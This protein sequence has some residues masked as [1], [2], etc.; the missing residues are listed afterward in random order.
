MVVGDL[1]GRRGAWLTDDRSRGIA[2]SARV[3]LARNLAGE[4]FP[5]WADEAGRRRVLRM[6]VEAAR[7]SGALPESIFISM[8]ETGD[9]DA[10]I[11]MERRLISAE[12]ADRGPGGGLLLQPD[13]SVA[14]LVNEEDHLR[15]QVIQPGMD[16]RGA[17]E[18][19]DAV[20][21]ALEAILAYAFSSE[22]GYL[23]ACPSNCGT[24]LRAS[25]MLHLLGLRLTNDLE[26][27][28]KALDRLRL[29]VRGIGGEGSDAAG[30]MFQVSNQETLGLDEPSIIADLSRVIADVARQ[31]MN[32]RLRIMEDAPH[33]AEDCVA[34]ALAILQNARVLQSEE[35]LDYLSALRLGVEL[36]LLRRLTM[37]EINELLLATQPGHLRQRMREPL[38]ADERDR[39]RADFVRERMAAVSLRA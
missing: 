12:L 34:R 14:L 3:R 35:A 6:V 18:R 31:E 32:A 33:L 37:A 7:A 9:T 15:I 8:D 25:V 2:I 23:T 39:L 38:E 29:A 22:L 20:D 13:E 19:A 30:H 27:V 11:L 5:D 24:G 26:P 16:L 36:R 10:R 21:T 4:S 17:W 28:L 1:V